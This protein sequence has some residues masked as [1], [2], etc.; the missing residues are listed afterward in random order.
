MA[1]MLTRN[2]TN[3]CKTEQKEGRKLEWLVFLGTCGLHIM[4]NSFKHGEKASNWN[5]KKLCSSLCKIFD[6][7]RL[8]SALAEDSDRDLQFVVTGG[9]RMS[10]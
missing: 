3:S 9:V 4:H 7:S 10:L 8:S 2:F 1:L 6:E 5:M